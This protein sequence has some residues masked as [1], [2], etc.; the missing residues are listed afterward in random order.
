MPES[1]RTMKK[2]EIVAMLRDEFPDMNVSYANYSAHKIKRLVARR[3]LGWYA[4]LR[5]LG[6]SADPTALTAITNTEAHA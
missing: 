4:A 5:V 2:H 1:L 6:I 3:D